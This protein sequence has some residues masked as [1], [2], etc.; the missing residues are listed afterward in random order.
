VTAI[1]TNPLLTS[2]ARLNNLDAPISSRSTL[3]A[4]DIP[5]GLT[6][7]EV[8]SAQS[9]TLT[10]TTGLTSEQAAQLAAL[11]TLGEIE[12][13]TVL[14]KA[15]D[16]SGLATSAQVTGLATQ[17]SVD[18]LADDV[19]T[20][21]E[22]AAAVLGASVEVGATVAQSLRLAN[23][24]LAGKVSGAQTGVETFRDL[25]DTTDVIVSTNDE[26]GNRTSVTKNL[27]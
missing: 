10:Q 20:A 4:Q 11:P 7:S 17:A 2:D 15:A 27:G 9:R 25:A 24:V 13:T 19:P 22:T 6:A 18:A 23:A 12:G 21:S 3:T 16:L 8:W 14:A 5:E 26:A 1:P